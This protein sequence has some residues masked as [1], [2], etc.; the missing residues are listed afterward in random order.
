MASGFTSKF[1]VSISSL[2]LTLCIN[3]S[4]QVPLLKV[5][6][7]HMCILSALTSL[8]WD[9]QVS[10]QHLSAQYRHHVLTHINAG[11]IS[12]SQQ[13]AHTH[14]ECPQVAA[15]EFT[16][17]SILWNNLYITLT[18]CTNTTMQPL[19][20][21]LLLTMGTQEAPELHSYGQLILTYIS[22]LVWGRSS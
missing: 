5:N 9:S 8:P 19:C 16:G 2:I 21:R 20:L 7:Q 12:E 6:K 22:A 1:A 11:I 13:T 10:L 15:S 3:S 4:M 14:S 17:E 18:L